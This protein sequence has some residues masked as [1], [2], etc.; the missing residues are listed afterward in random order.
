MAD[1]SHRSHDVMLRKRPRSREVREAIA[2]ARDIVVTG[3]A[4]HKTG[5]WL[6]LITHWMADCG[7]YGGLGGPMRLYGVGVCERAA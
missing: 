7:C 3:S 1:F 2:F 6:T 5:R 4:A